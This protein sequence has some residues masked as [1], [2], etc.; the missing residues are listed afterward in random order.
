MKK[1]YGAILSFCLLVMGAADVQAAETTTLG[2]F[3][4]AVKMASLNFTASDIKDSGADTAGYLGLEVFGSVAPNL[5]LGGE[6]GRANSKGSFVNIEVGQIN[7][8]A[9]LVPVEVNLKYAVQAARHVSIDFGGGFSFNHF[10]Y[11]AKAR[12]PLFGLPPVGESTVQ[13]VSGWLL[14]AQVFADV[15][16][17]LGPVFIGLNGKIEAVSADEG[18]NF[19]GSV[20]YTDYTNWRVGGQIGVRF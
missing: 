18:E 10:D 20:T 6:I 9:T 8:E 14:G 16:V 7:T 5:Y 2:N 12:T 13:H 19:Q 17:T 1:A 11:K 3:N 15:N 4:F